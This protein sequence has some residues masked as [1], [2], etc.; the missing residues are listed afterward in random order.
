MFDELEN[1]CR[2]PLPYEFYTAKDLWND[3]YIS[4]KMLELHLDESAELASRNK[5]FI[6]KSF[7]WMVSQFR[8]G[9]GTKICDFGCG[10]GLYA[11]RFAAKGAD[12]TGVDL[13][14]RSINYARGHADEN[15][16]KIDYINKNYLQFTTDK[17]FDLIT[18]IYLDLCPLSP[19]QR[20]IMLGKFRDYLADDGKVFLDVLTM[21]FFETTEE[22]MTIEYSAENGFWSPDLCYIFNNTFKYEQEK[23][24]LNKHSIFEKARTRTIFNWLQCYSLES[25][26]NEFQES[27]LRI[28]ENYADVS[29]A[30]YDPD[31][32]QM[33]IVAEKA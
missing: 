13:S 15:S 9:A 22:N 4:K 16:L 21:K 5:E 25:I 29:G 33:A 17:K 32:I 20:K 24:V 28:V 14:E 8:V 27:G 18:L 10:P 26:K 31:L 7:N 3:E 2:R 11:S 30:P 12:V 19:G 6:D 1:I 23:V